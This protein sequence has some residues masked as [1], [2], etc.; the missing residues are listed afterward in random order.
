M[1]RKSTNDGSTVTV[2]ESG[3]IPGAVAVMMVLPG[4]SGVRAV[5]TLFVLA[6]NVTEGA[7]VATVGLEFISVTVEFCARTILVDSD[8]ST[9]TPARI[10]GGTLNE[11][12]GDVAATS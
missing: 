9:G 10:S 4:A 12:C 3:R 2:I 1:R 8:M 7:T 5:C 11:S 6:S